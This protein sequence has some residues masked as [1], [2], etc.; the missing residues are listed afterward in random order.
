MVLYF[1]VSA[2][3]TQ[4][5]EEYLALAAE[6]QA[7]DFG[8]AQ[9]RHPLR[10]SI[11]S[12]FSAILENGKDVD[13]NTKASETWLTQQVD[14]ENHAQVWLNTILMY[15]PHNERLRQVKDFFWERYS[16]ELDSWRDQPLWA[17]SLRH[18]NATPYEILPDHWV[19][20]IRNGARKT[21][22]HKYSLSNDCDAN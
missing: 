4:P 16:K 7:S 20:Y 2:G 21:G 5:M 19:E 6:T 13:R 8:L 15:D 18:F 22:G 12:E 17:Y 3:L 14:F 10:E 11:S 9:A 1:D